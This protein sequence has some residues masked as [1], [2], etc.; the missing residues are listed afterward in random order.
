MRSL[1]DTIPIDLILLDQVLMLKC[2]VIDIQ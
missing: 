1:N 2:Y